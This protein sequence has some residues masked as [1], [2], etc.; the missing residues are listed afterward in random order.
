MYQEAR[1]ENPQQLTQSME[2]MA[3]FWKR[4]VNELNLTPS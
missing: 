4:V 3:V 2:R 1:Y